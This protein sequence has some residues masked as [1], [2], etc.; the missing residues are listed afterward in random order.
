[1]F[2]GDQRLGMGLEEMCYTLGRK[3]PVRA[4]VRASSDKGLHPR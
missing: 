2:S 1:M 3:V 4:F